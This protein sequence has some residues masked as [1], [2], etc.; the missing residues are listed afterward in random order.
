MMKSDLHYAEDHNSH[1]EKENSRKTVFN[2]LRKYLYWVITILFPCKT[3]IL[4][5]A[6]I[7][8][9]LFLEADRRELRVFDFHVVLHQVDRCSQSKYSQEYLN[10]HC[11]E[12]IRWCELLANRGVHCDHK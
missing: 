6:L 2:P 12:K 3:G 11:N 8:G 5:M 9:S 7:K 10:I 1:N 4:A